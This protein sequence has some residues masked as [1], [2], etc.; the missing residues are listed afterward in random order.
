MA[1]LLRYNVSLRTARLGASLLESSLGNR[2][3]GLLFGPTNRP[4]FNGYTRGMCLE[5]VADEDCAETFPARSPGDAERDWTT[6]ADRRSAPGLTT[7]WSDLGKRK[8]MQAT[9]RW[10]KSRKGS[11]SRIPAD[12]LR[13]AAPAQYPRRNDGICPLPR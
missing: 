1:A 10:M 13:D 8:V 9:V 5:F 6:L 7:T 2:R 12:R 4:M 3:D 11:A